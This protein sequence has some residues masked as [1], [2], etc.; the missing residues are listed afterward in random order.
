MELLPKRWV[1]LVARKIIVPLFPTAPSLMMRF[2][3]LLVFLGLG[4][5]L[6]Q[7]AP[8][9]AASSPT[10]TVATGSV[11]PA[12][13][14]A[15][16]NPDVVRAKLASIAAKLHFFESR[17]LASNRGPM[18]TYPDSDIRSIGELN[19]MPPP[20]SLWPKSLAQ[21]H[22]QLVTDL[23]ALKDADAALR[24]L[25]KD[26]DPKIR[27]L[28]LGALFER[29]DPQDLPVIAA[30]IN[31]NAATFPAFVLAEDS[32]ESSR[33]QN[34][35]DV[36]AT[37]I[38]FY[39]IAA[40]VAPDPRHN[41][42]YQGEPP[43]RDET[44]ALFARYWAERGKRA[45]CASWSLVKLERATRLT[46]PILPQ[47]EADVR[48][49]VAE[50]NQLPSP[51][52]EWG[53]LYAL[54]GEIGP[55]AP[56]VMPEATIVATAK[57]LG[58]EALM[59]FLELKPVSDDPDL[60]FDPNAPKTPLTGRR[61]EI[62]NGI[63]G[64][65]LRNASE[66]LRPSD[67][68]A[69]LAD[70]QRDFQGW[71]D[72][73][74]QWVAAANALKGLKDPGKAAADMQAAI[75]R[76][77]L[78]DIEGQ[79]QQEV[80]AVGLWKMA[81]AAQAPYLVNWFYAVLPLGDPNSGADGSWSFLREVKAQGRP[82]TQDLLKAMVADERFGQAGWPILE[83]LL[84]MANEGLAAPLV[85]A[86]TIYDYQPSAN[87]PDEIT[88]LASWRNLL[89]RRYGLPEVA[90][91]AAAAAKT[92]L[93]QPVHTE[94]FAGEIMKFTVSDDGHYVGIIL[95]TTPDLVEGTEADVRDAA[96][97][98]LI[99]QIPMRKSTG[100][101]ALSFPPGGDQIFLL[102]EDGKSSLG[103][104][105]AQTLTRGSQ[106][107]DPNVEDFTLA[108]DRAAKRMV[109]AQ[110]NELTCLDTVTGQSIWRR[111]DG[112]IPGR[113]DLVILS[114]DDQWIAAGGGF[115][116]PSQ[117][118]LLD[119]GNGTVTGTVGQYSDTV[120]GVAFSADSKSLF[121]T[122][123]TDNP[124]QWEV[125][126]GKLLREFPYHVG[127]ERGGTGCLNPLAVSPDG[128][129][130]AVISIDIPV[131]E[132]SI[133]YEHHVG[134]FEVAT[135]ELRWEVHSREGVSIMGFA[136]DGKTLYTAGSQLVETGKSSVSQLEAWK[137]Q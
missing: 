8:G 76:I 27:T 137:L 13:P 69:L 133:N 72:T 105:S 71:Q 15:T 120:N 95:E 10:T 80:L 64:L 18:M 128:R 36:A 94:N 41:T 65:I 84:P 85:E 114:P 81:G 55:D 134:V 135:G 42:E 97:G 1:L 116:S 130:V 20:D 59:R 40:N 32:K 2:L 70:S 127:S 87:R 126:T 33:P 30:L 129:W 123:A 132:G 104:L 92:I 68:D 121:T 112:K 74:E 31:D 125:G 9:T 16:V 60:A 98:K 34:V 102:D 26:P 53:L 28:A 113:G 48:R 49:A 117:V 46:E 14:S 82:D 111:Q 83:Q 96:T 47:N 3:S 100:W 61:N 103:N 115:N 11:S 43:A 56:Y 109:C 5:A 29:E 75:G 77:S 37:L 17:F 90:A 44:A 51:A 124:R 39:L 122:T 79:M 99:W 73:G 6:G 58:P 22:I 62:Y 38:N 7:T 19:A 88:E 54:Y 66:L 91:V 118:H 12:A 93:T 50:I 78:S 86:R 108:F 63:A 21:E 119:A 57:A 35:G 110:T 101:T 52:R 89:R 106:I 23:R 131:P 107:T 136:P 24:S 25:L 4:T 45:A 67:A